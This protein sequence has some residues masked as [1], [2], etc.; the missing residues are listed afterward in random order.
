MPPDYTEVR[1]FPEGSP[2]KGLKAAGYTT[3]S[4]GMTILRYA[5]VPVPAT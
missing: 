3:L 4:G 5:P 1:A 2:A